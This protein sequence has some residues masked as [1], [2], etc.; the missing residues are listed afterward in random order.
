MNVF[1][2]F[3]IFCAFINLSH[4]LKLL[5]DGDDFPEI[6]EEWEADIAFSYKPLAGK[7]KEKNPFLL[8]NKDKDNGYEN[9]KKGQLCEEKCKVDG[10][11]TDG[12]SEADITKYCT[13]PAGGPNKKFHEVAAKWAA[14]MV[15]GRTDI[16]L[17]AHVMSKLVSM[18][19][20]ETKCKKTV[21]TAFDIKA[22][23]C[24]V[25]AYKGSNGKVTTTT[26]SAYFCYTAVGITWA[27]NDPKV[28]N[29]DGEEF[30]IMATGTFSLLKLLKKGSVKPSLEVLA[31]VDRAGTRCGATYI[32]NVTLQ[33][34]WVEDV[35]VPQIQVR[36]ESAVPK[37]K[38]LQINFQGTWERL[39]Q[40]SLNTNI[41]K[42]IRE[43]T[44]KKMIL[45][46]EKIDVVVSIDSH[47]IYEEG[48]KTKRFANFLNI[49][50][51]G[52]GKIS[53]T[54]LGGLLGRDSHEAAAE[55]PKGCES[56]NLVQLEKSK[57][58]STIEVI[59]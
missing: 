31:N 40:L 23:T 58:I 21:V 45:Q 13:Q 59:P 33:G 8:T 44:A 28:K 16:K 7:C 36:A 57:M 30:E 4:S 52:I 5:I 3:V 37:T 34:Q 46:F 12:F 1:H 41:Q 38:A 39:A 15:A 56:T 35:G 54:S 29:M 17:C 14:H 6:S 43:A 18:T 26:A 32:Q 20:T 10:T 9:N 47:R 22:D 19:N 48:T 53:G 55:I 24:A 2:Y 51:D 49:A 50:F 27:K 42:A 25:L 11:N